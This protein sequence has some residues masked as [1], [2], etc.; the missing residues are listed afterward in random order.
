M[1]QYNDVCKI[2]QE[3]INVYSR[4][5]LT[6]TPKRLKNYFAK[7]HLSVIEEF[8]QAET[9]DEKKVLYKVGMLYKSLFADASRKDKNIPK[10]KITICWMNP[11]M[12]S[13]M[14]RYNEVK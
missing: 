10:Q 13:V 3:S 4:K 1:I 7:M 8:Q 5:C 14:S 6:A 11:N 2:L 9:M 12:G